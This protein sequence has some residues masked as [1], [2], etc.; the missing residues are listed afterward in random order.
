MIG[1]AGRKRHSAEEIV[2]KLRRADELTS[3]GSSGED[4]HVDCTVE[5][6]VDGKNVPETSSYSTLKATPTSAA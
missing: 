2:R 4:T 6:Q 5:L 1:V 3:A